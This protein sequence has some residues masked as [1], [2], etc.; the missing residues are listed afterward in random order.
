MG[1]V[2]EPGHVATLTPPQA[3]IAG[4]RGPSPRRRGGLS[5]GQAM[6]QVQQQERASE[7]ARAEIVRVAEL[8]AALRPSAQAPPAK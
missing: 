8:D 1:I 7:I 3:E 6:H 5:G 2:S 4:Y